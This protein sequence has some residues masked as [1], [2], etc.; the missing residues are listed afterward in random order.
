MTYNVRT[1]ILL[2]AF[3]R[4][5]TT[6]KVFSAIRKVK[7]KK[8]FISVDGPRN[9]FEKIKVDEVKKIV[10]N[11]DWPCTVKKIFN[12]KN[13]GLMQTATNAFNY[14]FKNAEQG[15][16]LEDDCLANESFFKFCEEMLQKYKD[17][18]KIM[19]ISGDNF[20]RGWKR[21]NY[22]YYFSK[23][24]HGWGW[25]TWRRAWKKYDATMKNYPTLRKNLKNIFPNKI[26]RTH[27]RNML[28]DA[29]FNNQ[30]AVD[31]RWMYTIITNDGLAILPNKNLVTNIGF[32]N[33]STHTKPV[34]S[35][36]SLPSFD[37]DFP[38]IHPQ[39]I[40]RDGI[41]DERY[42]KWVFKNKIKKYFLVF[43]GIN[44]LLK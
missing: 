28:D 38:L 35:Y 7:P 23:N 39:I 44:R 5:D 29:Y 40:A 41:S 6:E 4:P 14:L 15:I 17:N 34:D 13:L 22:S 24:P 43:T 10:S 19:H 9:D 18:E 16:I 25:A 32:G 31:I 8:L 11:V 27:I 3:N 30:N 37:M 26:E 2:L 33:D 42:A 12:K 36:L 1:P 21:N 20:Q